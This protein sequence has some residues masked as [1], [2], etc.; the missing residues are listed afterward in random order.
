VNLE[1]VYAIVLAIALLGEHRDLGARFYLGVAVILTLVLA[2]P[3]LVRRTPA[4]AHPEELTAMEDS[5]HD[6]PA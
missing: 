5:R 1:P 6:G 3:L 2:Y 4:A